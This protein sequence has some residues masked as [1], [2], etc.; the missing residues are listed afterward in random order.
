MPTELICE[1]C[2]ARGPLVK[3]KRGYE[4]VSWVLFYGFVALLSVNVLIGGWAP[5][6]L[7]WVQRASANL[8]IGLFGAWALHVLFRWLTGKEV[9][10]TCGA[11][12]AAIPADSPR[13]QT[14]V[15]QFSASAD[16]EDPATA[17][18]RGW[19]RPLAAAVPLAAFAAAIV[20]S[21]NFDPAPREAC[22]RF[23]RNVVNRQTGGDH[24]D[25]EQQVARFSKD[26]DAAEE[27]IAH[28]CIRSAK[29]ARDAW[30]RVG[31][32]RFL[33]CARNSDA[34][35]NLQRCAD[36]IAVEQAVV[37]RT[38]SQTVHAKQA[39]VVTPRGPGVDRD[40]EGEP[41]V[42]TPPIKA[43]RI[44]APVAHPTSSA[45]HTASAPAVPPTTDYGIATMEVVEMDSAEVDR[46]TVAK[47]IRGSRAAI[48]G[49]YEA[50]LAKAR[51][52]KGK[53]VPR[54][55]IS[56]SGRAAEIEIE[57]DTVGDPAL[58]NCVKHSLASLRFSVHPDSEVVVA[59][60]IAFR[61]TP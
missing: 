39:L 13:G 61:P 29:E 33:D 51:T 27:K 56:T 54:F 19:S 46:E 49:C 55:V 43:P 28:T 37:A 53:L 59:V 16:K 47:V 42:V 31:Y 15:R 34:W 9:C 11:A 14:L 35:E 50:S 17:R 3:S 52:L 30:G 58:S 21:V 23:A 1:R 24:P 57:E 22:Y 36:Q 26:A 41:P 10:P 40:G 2:G 45:T 8:G 32:V 25:V 60:S 7:L 38:D 18:P 4:A 48:D 6:D 5:D 44:P 12:K 20:W